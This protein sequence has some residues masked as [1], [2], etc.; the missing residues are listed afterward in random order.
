MHTGKKRM[1]E[2]KKNMKS[3]LVKSLS[4]RKIEI[5]LN[6]LA[7]TVLLA[8]NLKYV[9]NW[10]DTEFSYHANEYKRFSRQ[11]VH[12]KRFKMKLVNQM[13][14]GEIVIDCMFWSY[15]CCCVCVLQ[16]RINMIVDCWQLFIQESHESNP[17]RYI[18]IQSIHFVAW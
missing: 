6:F 16:R 3:T 14:H 2:E 4:F 10:K 9:H 12:N 15:V 17:N 7:F 8:A 1:K 5:L 18:A 13:R 11:K